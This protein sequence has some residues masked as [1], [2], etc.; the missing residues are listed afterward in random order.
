MK[1]AGMVLRARWFLT[2]IGALLLA[3]LVWLLG[4][5]IAVADYRPL[6][7][8]TVR[9]VCVVV[10]LITWGIFNLFAQLRDRQQNEGLV[11]AV[12]S[13]RPAPESVAHDEEVAVIGERFRHA[14]ATLKQSRLGGAHGR[15]YLYQLPWYILVGP[16]GAGKTTALVN[17]GLKFPLEEGTGKSAVK[18][19]G[20]TRNCDW[21]FTDEA[22][23]IDT[24][25][26]YVT[27]DSEASVDSAGWSS[28]LEQLKTYRP[29]QPI[30]GVLVAVSLTDLLAG[31]QAERERQAHAVRQRLRELQEAFRLRFPVYVLFTKAD[32]V[33]GFTEFFDSL[34]REQRDQVWGVTFPIAAES[35]AGSEVAMFG[36]EFDLLIDR[37][38]DHMLTRLHDESDLHRRNLIFGFPTQVA[39]LKPL[40]ASFL[41]EIFRP[42]RLEQRALLRGFYFTSGTQEGTPID[43][44]MGAMA[45]TFGL[46]PQRLSAHSG[47]GRSYFLARLLREVIFNEAS[48]V[49]L[50]PRAQRRQR[51]VQRAA[52]ATA[53][54]VAIVAIGGWIVSY[55]ENQDLIQRVEA[56]AA[57]YTEQVRGI[58]LTRVAEGDLPRVLPALNTLRGMPTGYDHRDDPVPFSLRLGQYQGDKLGAQAIEAYHQ[59]LN[60]LMLPRLL[61]HLEDR[62]AKNLDRSEVLYDGLKVYL[63]LGRQGALDKD[64]VRRWMVADWGELYAGEANAGGRQALQAHL[65]ALLQHPLRLIPLNGPLVEK[66]R[67]SLASLPLADRAYDFIK[68]SVAARQLPEW[69]IVDHGG[70]SVTRVFTRKSGR[71]LVEGIPGLYT[72]GGFHKVF[73]PALDSVAAEVAGDSWV[74]GPD[75]ETRLDAKNLARLKQDVLALYYDDY[76]ARWDFL[77]SDLAIVSFKSSEHAVETLN[78]LAGPNSPLR[79]ILVA[80]AKETTL[81]APPPP[82]GGL[83]SA[84]ASAEAAVKQKLAQSTRLGGALTSPA[85]SA[86]PPPGKFIDD[87]FQNLHELVAGTPAPIDQTITTLNKVYEQLQITSLSPYELQQPV[88][89]GARAT[90]ILDLKREASRLPAPVGEWVTPIVDRVG[91]I[92]KLGERAR[93]EQLWKSS[94]LPT[95]RQV[96][97]N[98]FPFERGAPGEVALQDFTRLFAPGGLVDDFF[99]T[100][101]KSY[102]DASTQPWRWQNV[103]LGISSS[104]L[105]QFQ[106]AERIRDAFFGGGSG[107]PL[108]RFEMQL[109]ALDPSLTQ[110]ALELD[111]QTATF[112]PGPA[113]PQ[114]LQW[115]GQG[116]GLAR[117]TFTPPTSGTLLMTGPWAW[118]R[119][120]DQSDVRRT[121]LSD[122]FTVRIA[123]DGKGASFEVRAASVVNPF[124]L[125][126]ELSAFRCPESF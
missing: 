54:L 52:Y 7:S 92:D 6:A 116:A 40:A 15:H 38:N 27:Q 125:R 29:R 70:P 67:R 30:N 55:G 39:S 61:V 21:W 104:V 93:I 11:E 36:P 20:G 1:R 3:A 50:D 77:L 109:T 12:A 76:A 75:A 43:R 14:L 71:P 35:A 66:A 119:L 47:S 25:G 5:L 81:T 85:A 86:A 103:D 79:L 117:V 10:I 45:A 53:G 9:L 123:N 120:L 73:L 17:S 57:K 37:L 115:P 13:D 82:E 106:R 126:G 4:P 80:A 69:R 42:S 95:C 124:I 18:G 32:L 84:E 105:A 19:V 94:V 100:N 46:D 99:K 111:G 22:V 110:I 48:L 2:L 89:G 64:L 41:D 34:S 65:E 114:A 68:Q 113:H 49:S 33:A 60:G 72:Y 23:L 83:V 121:T 118:F 62:L 28:F 101:L 90:A 88:V 26:R 102:V 98:R 59:A 51:W 108:V 31:S 122:R 58:D 91:K 78:S 96:L 24:A 56:A 107:G 44:V 97:T 112:A 8:D 16:P 87:R 74:L 63:M